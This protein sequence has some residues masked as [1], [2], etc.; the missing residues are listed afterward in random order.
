[1]NLLIAEDEPLEREVIME[2][3]KRHNPGIKQ[4]IEANNGASAVEIVSNESIDIVLM[5]IKMPILDGISAAKIMKQNTPQLKILFLTAYN[6]F[7]YALN[8][9][10]IGAEDFLLKPVRPEEFIE[11]IKKVIESMDE[12]VTDMKDSVESNSV[13][14]MITN[15]INVKLDHKITLEQVARY[16]HLHPQYVSRLF[17]QQTGMTITEFITVK[18]IE[19]SKEY[20]RNSQKAITE[21]SQSCGFTDANYFTR[22]FRKMEGMPP[23]QFRKNEQALKKEKINR[24]YFNNIM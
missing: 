19:K 23:K 16:V 3:V 9:I 11:A 21:I 13:V 6:D 15:Y 10:K 18:R 1:M 14:E 7:D 2:M 8:T 22:V 5:D 20:L 24:H 17:K 4:C 12:T